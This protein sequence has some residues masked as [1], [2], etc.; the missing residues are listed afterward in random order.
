MRCILFS[1][2]FLLPLRSFSQSDSIT[3]YF[4]GYNKKGESYRV[5]YN[6]KLRLS[7]KAGVS[8]MY[9]F[10]IPRDTA[11]KSGMV[12]FRPIHVHKK[13]LFGY[14]ATGSR[15]VYMNKKYFVIRRNPMLRRKF[16][17]ECFWTDDKPED[18]YWHP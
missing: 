18:P 1:L 2:I 8:F 14:R 15:C 9:S 5:Y 7:F 12:G 17:V 3:V 16:S 10:K 6:D 13:K 11:L 4:L